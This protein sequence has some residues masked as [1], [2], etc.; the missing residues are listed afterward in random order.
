MTVLMF[1]DPGQFSGTAESQYVMAALKGRHDLVKG[2]VAGYCASTTSGLLLGQRV[3]VVTS[4][5]YGVQG[6]E[7]PHTASHSSSQW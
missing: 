6:C 2:S 7:W 1:S 5:E 4:G 3:L